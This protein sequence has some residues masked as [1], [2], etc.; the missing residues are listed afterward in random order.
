[1]AV[2]VL[3][4]IGMYNAKWMMAVIRAEQLAGATKRRAKVYMRQGYP[5]VVL[6][7]LPLTKRSIT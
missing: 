6:S 3:K 4:T 7:S 2:M 1:M 5:V